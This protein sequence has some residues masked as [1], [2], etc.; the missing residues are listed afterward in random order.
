MNSLRLNCSPFENAFL[1]G[2][3]VGEGQGRA[4]PLQRAVGEPIF[5]PE[6]KKLGAPRSLE[7]RRNGWHN[8]AIE[9]ESLLVASSANV[10]LGCEVGLRG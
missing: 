3:R 1:A 8:R 7:A 5:L 6:V 4:A 2:I 9:T 10:R